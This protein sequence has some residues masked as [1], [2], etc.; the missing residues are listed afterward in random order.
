VVEFA[1]GV[2]V[3]RGTAFNSL[4]KSKMSARSLPVRGALSRFARSEETCVS[5]MVELQKMHLTEY[6][7]TKSLSMKP[8]VFA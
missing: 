3:S 5:Y 6:S 4:Q 8:S 2:C 7:F 1:F